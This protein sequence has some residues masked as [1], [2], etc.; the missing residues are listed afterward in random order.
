MDGSVA[1]ACVRVDVGGNVVVGEGVEEFVPDVSNF[2]ETSQIALALAATV[3]PVSPIMR[4]RRE[5]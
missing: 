3:S 4:T 2:P 5:R 1:G